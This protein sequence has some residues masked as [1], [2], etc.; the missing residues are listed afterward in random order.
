MRGETEKM[1]KATVTTYQKGQLL[2]GLYFFVQCKGEN[3]GRPL[4]QPIA[5]CWV[6]TVE[7]AED[8]DRYY[9]LSYALWLAGG[10]KVYLRGSVVP[11]LVIHEY[12]ACMSKAECATQAEAQRFTES[13]E[14]VSRFEVQLQQL[15]HHLVE[16]QQAKRRSL[17]YLLRL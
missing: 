7:H 14:N 5:N 6:V 15:R 10:F 12:K 17:A 8:L 1:M 4:R 2:S 11:F 3:S 16:L 13:V 9:Y